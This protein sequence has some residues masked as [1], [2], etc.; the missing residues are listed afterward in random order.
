MQNKVDEDFMIMSSILQTH[1]WDIC[2]S[3]CWLMLVS[4]RL[5]SP[6]TESQ[7]ELLTVIDILD[8]QDIL[9]KVSLDS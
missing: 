9:F 2:G 6:L 5:T 8:A 1:R 3:L 7:Y 4:P